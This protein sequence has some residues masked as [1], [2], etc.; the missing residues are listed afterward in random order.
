[1]QS[2]FRADIEGLRALAV[3]PILLFHLN[4]AFCPGGFAGVD[5]FF[6]ISGY[7]ITRM[8][9]TANS[10][11]SFKTFYTRRFYRIFPALLTTCQI[12]LIVGWIILTPEDYSKL[13]WSAL[14]AALGVSNFYFYG[15][16]DYFSDANIYHALLHTWSLGVE[17]QFYLFWPALVILILRTRMP[18]LPVLALVAVV[19][20]LS[21]LVMQRENADMTFYLMPFRIFEF[22]AGA[23][24]VKL[25]LVWARHSTDQRNGVLGAIG[26]ALLLYTF[27]FLH[28]DLP[29]PST[30]TLAPTIGTML[31]I[32]AG[33]RG[34]WR[35]AL[36]N[37]VFR[38]L[39][40]I[41]YSLYLVHWPVLVFYRYYTIVPPSLVELAVLGAASIVIASLMF[42]LVEIPFRNRPLHSPSVSQTP[43]VSQTASLRYFSWV[44]RTWPYVRTPILTISTLLFFSASALVIA[45]SGFPSRIDEKRVQSIDKGLTFA[46]DLCGLKRS[47]CIFGDRAAKTVVYVVGDSHALNLIHGLDR[48]FVA[49][50]IKG[51]AFYDHGCL[52]ALGT[53]RF[54]KGRRDNKCA[55]RVQTAF[56]FLRG[57][58]DPVIIASAFSG[59]RNSIGPPGALSPLRQTETEYFSW[60]GNRI[61]AS[62]TYINADKR[63]IILFKQSYST[64]IDLAKCLYRP[65][66]TNGQAEVPTKCRA[67]SRNEVMKNYRH[68]DQMIDKVSATFSSVRVIDPKLIFCKSE[69]CTTD[70]GGTLF[71]R[72]TTHLTIHGSDY[73]IAGAKEALLAGLQLE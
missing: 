61:L 5:V 15:A 59:Y 51:I 30:F 22:A 9:V 42:A 47:R 7:L 46:G 13:S 12:S 38:F 67:L 36:S 8:I 20:F 54:I 2:G 33:Q 49:K 72:D 14:A 58:T 1:M 16:L 43:L 6:V 17:E 52:F 18:V 28:E 25:E 50:N 64:G 40:R 3:V 19:S 11:F 65:T 62:L 24:L 37:S 71:F 60:L 31:L 70:Q 68:A 21:T 53:T 39:G 63:P 69:V 45:E 55:Q 73:L 29:W 10:E 26:M 4:V 35:S 56:D 41:S 34:I 23:S 44:S 66:I 27:F 57:T 32:L 48:L